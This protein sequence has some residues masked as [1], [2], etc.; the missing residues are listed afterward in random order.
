VAALSNNTT[1]QSNTAIGAGAL[2]SNTTG[3][4]NVALGLEAG[5][6]LTGDNNIDIGLQVRG[7]AGESNT[8]RIGDN[9]PKGGQS[10]C[11]I[12]G[13]FDGHI[14]EDGFVISVNADNQLGT[15]GFSGSKLRI[16]DV[17]RDHK[18][19]AELEAVVAALTAQLK[20]QAAQIRT[21]SAQLQINK[22][23]TKVVLSNH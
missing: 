7:L 19:V 17:I 23:A 16:K 4:S 3:N 2:L 11:Y 6:D 9:L 10:N 1:G 8:V 18:T 15:I 14:G 5:A 12:G 20:D 13:M 21:V 22:P